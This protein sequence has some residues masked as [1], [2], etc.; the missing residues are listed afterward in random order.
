MKL[1]NYKEEVY[2]CSGCGLCQSVCPVYKI[3]KT[4]CAVSRGKFKLLNAIINK[5]FNYSKKTSKFMDLCLHCQACTEFCPSGIDAQKII[6][7]AQYDM[8]EQGIFSYPKFAMIQILSNKFYMIIVKYIIE[9]LRKT[10]IIEY[11][12]IFKNKELSLLKEAL[13]VKVEPL[14]SP[15]ETKKKYK[16]LYFKG[17]INNY[18]NPSCENAVRKILDNTQIEIVEADFECCGLP[19]KSSGNFN[20]FKNIIK[21]NLALIDENVDYI[22]FD[23]ASCLSTFFEYENFIDKNDKKKFNKI[24]KKFI[25]IYELLEKIE[26]EIEGPSEK[27]TV[28]FHYPCHTRNSKEQDIIKNILNKIPNTEYVESKESNSCCGAA[29]SYIVTNNKISKAISINKAENIINTNSNI[30]LTT[31]PVCVLGLKQGL[32]EKKSDIQVQ[33]LIEFLA[34]K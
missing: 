18:I 6:E 21:K 14:T 34:Q 8:L 25:S 29:G 2:K 9:I 22:L 1:K 32:L 12:D 26:Y 30:V 5:N 33:Q 19:L 7:T 20:E 10:H 17:C 3:L 15:S 4:E 27:Q 23:C 31:C 13:T 16:A 28:T 11:L 24:K